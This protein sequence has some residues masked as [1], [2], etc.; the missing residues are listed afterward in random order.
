[1]LEALVQ[2]YTVFLLN[3][4]GVSLSVC[5]KVPPTVYVRHYKPATPLDSLRFGRRGWFI[6]FGKQPLGKPRRFASRKP[7]SSTLF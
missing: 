5:E 4:M 7:E 6:G 2:T 3:G 1:M